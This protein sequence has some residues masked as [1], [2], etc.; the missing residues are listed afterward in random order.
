MCTISSEIQGDR[1]DQISWMEVSESDTSEEILC[2]AKGLLQEDDP[3][4]IFCLIEDVDGEFLGIEAGVKL[5]DL[6][7]LV[8]MPAD[9]AIERLQS[10][11]KE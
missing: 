5:S 1:S 4:T 10:F 3:S 8:Q 9:Q 7:E 11:Q 2:M 6:V